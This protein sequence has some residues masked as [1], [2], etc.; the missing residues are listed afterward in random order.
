MLPDTA[1]LDFVQFIKL[2]LEQNEVSA[3]LAFGVDHRLLK[4]FKCVNNLKEVAMLEEVLVVFGF[5]FRDDGFNRNQEG[6]LIE[7]VF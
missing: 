6:I 7:V 2:S 1:V 3:L 4:F 5:S